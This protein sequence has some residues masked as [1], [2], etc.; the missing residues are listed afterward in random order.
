[1]TTQKEKLEIGINGYAR[2]WFDRLAEKSKSKSNEQ[3]LKGSYKWVA[4]Q[5]VKAFK[6]E[7]SIE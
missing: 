7:N 2:A 6:E 4:E 3:N 1:M 5:A